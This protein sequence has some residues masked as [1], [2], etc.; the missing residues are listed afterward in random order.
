[1]YRIFKEP[2]FD[3]MSH[4]RIAFMGSGLLIL[5]GIISLIVHGGPRYGIDFT[6]GSL[7]QVHF[8]R[9][10]R[11]DDLRASISTLGLGAATI[12]RFGTGNDFLIATRATEEFGPDIVGPAIR[13]ISISPNPTAGSQAITLKVVASDEGTGDHR[14]SRMEYFLDTLGL[15]GT[16]DELSEV[17]R[18]DSP[19]ETAIVTIPSRDWEPGTQHVVSVRACDIAGN[20][21]ESRDATIY[22]TSAGD[23][24]VPAGV[25]VQETVNF[26]PG[27]G[28]STTRDVP[29]V[30]LGSQVRQVL[31]E[32]FPDN[33]ARID[34]EEVVGPR[35]SSGLQRRAMWVIL[36]GMLGILV[37]VTIRFTYRIGVAAVVALLH[38]LLITI[39]IFS[40][41]NK[42]F[43]IPIIAALLTI[44]GY[45]INDSIVLSDR[46]RENLRVKRGHLFPKIVNFSINETLSRTIITSLTTFIVLIALL[47]FGGA[48][49]RDFALALAI[50]VLVGT[51][52]SI[53]VVAPIVTEWE[54]VSPS[55][56]RAS[57]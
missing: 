19:T 54:K 4:S 20:W 50:G 36:L 11:I 5:V 3:F 9:P 23:R 47:I 2:T 30:S 26:P 16:G 31:A 12:Q 27:P 56:T 14:I 34:R 22:T 49:I 48:V 8:D 38:D 52:S 43:T 37:Y 51:Y 57:R 18:F 46:I 21:G 42:E 10:I 13:T 41:L 1:M 55:Y 39:G 29:Q 15:T 25:T 53:F 40:L 28:S 17:D 44:V 33:P 7:I 35:I 6:G 32:G 45:S 24:T